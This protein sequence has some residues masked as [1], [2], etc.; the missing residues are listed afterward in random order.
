MPERVA[1]KSIFADET[2]IDFIL[3]KYS[4]ALP[5]YRQRAILMRDLGIDGALATINNAMLRVGELPVPVA[6]SIKRDLLTG[7]YIQA[8]ETHVDVQRT[9]IN[10]E[11]KGSV[12]RSNARDSTLPFVQPGPARLGRSPYAFR[13]A[14]PCKL[15][16]GLFERS[17]CKAICAIREGANQ[18]DSVRF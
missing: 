3:R 12:I 10:L 6:G 5:L 4:D 2:M 8:D 7:G 17:G 14:P 16:W 1:P 18:P 9:V 13:N 15:D 11:Q